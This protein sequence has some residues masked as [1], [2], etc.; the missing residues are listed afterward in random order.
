M[1]ELTNLFETSHDDLLNSLPRYQ[2]NLIQ[3]ITDQGNDYFITAEKIMAAKPSNTVGFGGNGG[4]RNIY[5]NKIL[6]ELEKYICGDE[7]Y[8]EERAKLATSGDKSVQFIT[9]AISSAI[10]SV[11]GVAGAFLLPLI[12][13]LIMSSGKITINGWCEARK[14]IR[15]S[16]KE[17]GPAQED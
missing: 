14:E 8:K 15:A 6:E 10:G 16:T 12:V 7:K 3:Q 5:L 11:L 1:D 17:V 4:Q 13:L 9:G 2:R